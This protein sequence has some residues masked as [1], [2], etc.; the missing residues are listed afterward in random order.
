MENKNPESVPYIVHESIMAREER[1]IR[2]LIFALV[3]A[4]LLLFLS[5]AVW[6][7]YWAQYDYVSDET[8]TIDGKSG[9][10]NYIGNGGD[11]YNGENRG[12][13]NP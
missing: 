10:A 1:H 5:N 4:V 12:E 6:L 13:E 8:I 2:R 9:T 11:I 7:Y 3:V